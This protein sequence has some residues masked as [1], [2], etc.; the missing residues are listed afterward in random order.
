MNTVRRL[1]LR[2]RREVYSKFYSRGD[3][4]VSRSD[5]AREYGVPVATISNILGGRVKLSKGHRSDKGKK[6]VPVDMTDVNPADLIDAGWDVRQ[7]LEYEAMKILDELPK[8]RINAIE[9]AKIINMVARIQKQLKEQ[10]I[11]SHIKRADAQVIARIIRRFMPAATETDVIKIF[12]E[13]L[14]RWKME[15]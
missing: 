8:K 4:V 13:E 15:N 9:R 7:H 14:D 11:E 1:T 3:H 6:K 5:L 2:E 12:R 10:E